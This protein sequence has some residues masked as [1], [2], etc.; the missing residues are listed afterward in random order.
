MGTTSIIYIYPVS[1][2]ST[3]FRI[4][5]P[6]NVRLPGP[7]SGP[8]LLHQQ[9]PFVCSQDGEQAG[10]Q[11]VSV[12]LA[13]CWSLHCAVWECALCVCKEKQSR[14]DIRLHL[15]AWILSVLAE[16]YIPRGLACRQ[17]QQPGPSGGEG[18]NVAFVH[19]NFTT[20]THCVVF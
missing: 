5:R 9:S 15:D 10:R 8:P 17:Q 20:L 4:V 16:R 19:F 1:K 6:T 11:S 2:T 3:C 12:S 7:P 13:V 14:P 18:G